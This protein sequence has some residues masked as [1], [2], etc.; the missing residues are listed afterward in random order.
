MCVFRVLSHNFAFF[1]S[2]PVQTDATLSK[3]IRMSSALQ[4]HFT[5]FVPQ[6]IMIMYYC[7]TIFLRDKT[8]I[9][10]RIDMNFQIQ[11]ANKKKVDFYA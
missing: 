8:L 10:N 5:G 2:V 7:S 1:G 6:N 4:S 9:F 11:R 3:S